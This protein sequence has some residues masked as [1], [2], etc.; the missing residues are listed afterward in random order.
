MT[1]LIQLSFLG[2]ILAAC[3]GSDDSSGIDRSRTL[4][5][6]NA[7]ELSDLCEFTLDAAGGAGAEFEC[8]DG[9]TVTNDTMAECLEGFEANQASC[10]VGVVE[11]CATRPD[12]CDL[13]ACSGLL[14]CS[15]L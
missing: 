6:L 12:P 2:L 5:D 1:R 10:T 14:S 7:G 4:G 3:G 11:D 8:G 9:V 15:Q 13:S